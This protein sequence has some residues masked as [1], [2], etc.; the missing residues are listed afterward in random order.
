MKKGMTLVI[1][2]VA[3]TVMLI[4]ITAASV[5]GSG[6]ITTANFEEYNS[7][8]SRVSNV[9]NEYY[10]ENKELPV[11]GEVISAQSLGNDFLVNL[12][13][14]SDE[15]NPLFVV[16]MTK[17]T[18]STI[19]KGRGTISSQDVFLV[20]QNTQNIYYMKGFKYKS[21]VYYSN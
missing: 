9:V 3:I 19:K 16:D 2:T 4:L 14:K 18:D 17:I 1:V 20:T 5:I 10:M 11:T 15:Q 7:T 21:H 12:K 6:A 13:E 8:L